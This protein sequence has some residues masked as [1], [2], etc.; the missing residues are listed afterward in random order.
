[1]PC[2]CQAKTVL[3]RAYAM[4]K[5]RFSPFLQLLFQERFQ[6][7]YGITTVRNGVFFGRAQFGHGLARIRKIK[8][9]Y[10]KRTKIQVSSE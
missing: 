9:G 7:L 2:A 4:D 6:R 3:V 5:P 10:D 8:S 1:M